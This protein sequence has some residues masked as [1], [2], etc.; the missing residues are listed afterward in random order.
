MEQANAVRERKSDVRAGITVEWVT[1]GWMFVEVA[2][3]VGAAL[4]AGSIALMAF[5]LDSGIELISAGVLV[6]RL[7]LER[8][9]EEG[10]RIQHAERRA[11]G[12]VGWTLILLA[13]YV[14][15]SAAWG[16][17]RH[18]ASDTTTWGIAIAVGAVVIMPILVSVKRRIAAR[19]GSAALK[20]D[21]AEGI[22][23]TYMA[24]VL[25]VGLLLRSLLGWW[26][27]DPLAALGIVYFIVR[28]GRE[29][30]EVSR[31]AGADDD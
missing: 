24:A 20:A 3:S 30:I 25:L 21:A 31:G 6:W 27:A 22:V 2:V 29:A 23:C 19:I 13:L 5:G 11:A 16:L 14:V 17:W 26:W 15:A 18:A 4:A 9:G 7:G 10:E 12:I 1:I 8:R 28:E